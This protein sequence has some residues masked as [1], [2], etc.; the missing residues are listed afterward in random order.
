MKK[1]LQTAGLM[2]LAGGAAVA[3]REML[4]TP[5][6]HQM[7][8][9]STGGEASQPAPTRAGPPDTVA[10]AVL[11]GG[12]VTGDPLAN[13]PIDCVPPP[14][15]PEP[16][17]ET[18]EDE[19]LAVLGSSG[20]IDSEYAQRLWLFL[21]Q[22]SYRQRS[23]GFR[24]DW[25]FHLYATRNNL[26]APLAPTARGD[27]QVQ[28]GGTRYGFQPFGGDTLYNEI[29]QWSMV[30]SLN[31]LLDGTLPDSG[32]GRDLLAASYRQSGST[33][34]P[35]WAFHQFAVRENLGPALSDSYRLTVDGTEYALQVFALDTLYNPVPQWSDVR[36]LSDTP[37]GSLHT[38]LWT[39]TYRVGGAMFQATD[40]FFRL[41]SANQLGTPLSAIY[42][43]NF[44]GATIDVQ[45]FAL[46]TLYARPGL[47][48]TRQS[49]LSRPP[50][51]ETQPVE[52]DLHGPADALSDKRP[53]FNVLPLA[54]QPRISQ[55][56]GY[57]RFAAGN[58]RRFYGATQG[59]HS[60]VDFAVPVGT[61]L[62]AIDYGVVVW[63]GNNVG[64]VSFGAGPRSIIVRYGNTYALYGH[65]SSESVQPGQSVSPGQELG[66]SGFP[67]A[68]HLHF[69]LR[70]VPDAMLGNGDP[71]QRPQ[72]PG[73]AINPLEYFSPDLH[74]YF[75]REL[76]RLGG[77]T[78]HFCVGDLREQDRITFGAPV[79]TRPCQ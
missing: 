70:P 78:G 13:D 77:S 14:L 73:Y 34:M 26:G 47:P 9:P 74:T 69:E 44:E 1:M 58:G 20:D 63:A 54:G 32:L 16:P 43:V 28:V 24:S 11:G 31:G 72:N 61:P 60:G 36:R 21:Q 29:P 46:D 41:A 17:G 67:S 12:D 4:R 10:V 57:T 65:T 7:P 52:P 5:P 79:D 23:D 75:E 51:F 19:T 50:I 48:V 27:E 25:A 66:R 30:Q 64:G 49:D 6:A 76:G 35:G 53:V 33:L 15:P 3:I 62:L 22:E 59:Q 68:P 8:M 56:Y 18:Q 45:V 55:F 71:N 2:A 42:Q 38:A 40:P 39:E 37:P